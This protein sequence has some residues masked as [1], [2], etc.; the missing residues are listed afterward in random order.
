MIVC[1][2][3]ISCVRF[4]LVWLAPGHA[5]FATRQNNLLLL[6]KTGVLCTLSDVTSSM[7]ASLLTSLHCHAPTQCSVLAKLEMQNPGGSVK[8]RSSNHI[9]LTYTKYFPLPTPFSLLPSPFSL[10]RTPYKLLPT[11]YSLLPTPYTLLPTAYSILHF[12]YS[13][14][15]TPCAPHFVLPTPYS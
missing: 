13:L 3:S 6:L 12:P 11:S 5:Y 8:D 7:R 14:L 2:V 10:L 4:V 15:H 1:P 9:I